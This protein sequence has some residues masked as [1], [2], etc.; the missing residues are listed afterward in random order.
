MKIKKQSSQRKKILA[1]VTGMIVLLLLSSGLYLYYSSYNK[2]SDNPQGYPINYGPPSEDQK[3]AGDKIKDN[4]NSAG[5]DDRQEVPS[6]NGSHNKTD[7]PVTIIDAS[8]YGS[9]IDVRAYA[10]GVTETDGSC[11][12]T[13][14]QGSQ[15]VTRTARTAVSASTTQCAEVTIPI[16]ELPVRGTWSV[17]VTYDSSTSTGQSSSA[18]IEVR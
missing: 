9:N 14:T 12:V 2:Q 10:A 11:T 1:I 6:S 17:V 7:V 16:T 4:S 15:K 3:Q 8:Q 5:T 13:L 18:S